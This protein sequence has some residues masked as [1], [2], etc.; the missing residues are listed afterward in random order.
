[1]KDESKRRS[2]KAIG[3][4]ANDLV[5]RK[6]TRSP[7]Q[8]HNVQS[9]RTLIARLPTSTTCWTPKTWPISTRR[10]WPLQFGLSLSSIQAWRLGLIMLY[11]ASVGRT[12]RR[13]RVIDNLQIGDEERGDYANKLESGRESHSSTDSEHGR[14]KEEM[15]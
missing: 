13:T 9:L 15:Q 8:I 12:P 7:R 3:L 14:R 5:S 6:S 11:P 1:M 10:E 4:S 2:T